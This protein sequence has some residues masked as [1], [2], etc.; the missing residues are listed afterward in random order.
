[1]NDSKPI[2][3]IFGNGYVTQFLVPQLVLQGWSV[4]VTS[5]QLQLVKPIG[6]SRLIHFF[7]P[8]LPNIISQSQAILSTVPTDPTAIDPVL[9]LY[10]D[11]IRNA[12]A[13][14]GYLSAT[15]VYGDHGGAWVTE[16]SSCQPSYPKAKT[17][18]L[19]EQKWLSLHH[20]HQT[21]VHIFRLSGI[22]GPKRN[23]LIA[24]DQGKKHVVVKQNHQFSRIHVAD[25]CQV[26][27]ASIAKPTPGEIFNV[28]DNQPAPIEDVYHFAC[29]LLGR[30]QLDQVPFEAAKLSKPAKQFFNDHKQV[31]SQKIQSQLGIQ[32]RYPDYKTGLADGCY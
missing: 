10:A 26:I 11:P 18:H 28:S 23:A 1:M 22:Y 3:V 9:A 15:N 25:I 6:G 17:R 16:A 29:Q 2:I 21:P 19:A 13:W 24:I 8:D 14:V 5:R 31:S 20:N 12:K 4:Y 7:D 30:D 32:W 27:L